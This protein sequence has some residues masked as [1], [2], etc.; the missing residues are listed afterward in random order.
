MSVRLPILAPASASGDEH[1]FSAAFAIL[2]R[3]LHFD[4][5]GEPS[6]AA[7]VGRAAFLAS[8]AVSEGHACV[9]LQEW[10]GRADAPEGDTGSAL[11]LEAW[12]PRLRESPVIA[13]ADA[14]DAFRPLVLDAAGRLFLYR[15]WDYEGR[16]AARLRALN[17]EVPL[18]DTKELR[19]MLDR[20]FPPGAGGEPDW[21]KVAAATA[22]S[23]RLAGISGGPGTGKTTTVV[24][25]LAILLSVEPKLRV[26]LAAP[27]G[28][29]AARMQESIRSQLESL[30]VPEEVRTR[31]PDTAYT[32]HR[33]LG[34]IPDSVRFRHHAEN[35]LAFDLVIV[36]EASM[37]DL[38]LAAKLLDALPPS[39]RLILLGDKDQLAS[40]ETGVVFAEVCAARGA[41][42][43]GRRQIAD[44]VGEKLPVEEGPGSGGL[45]DAVVWLTHSYRFTGES[46][47]GRL[48]RAVNAGDRE[49]AAKLLGDGDFADLRWERQLPGAR[50]LA[51][52]LVE[53]YAAFIE[54][55]RRGEPADRVLVEFDRYRVL[56][57]QREGEFGA[58]S[59]SA[60]IG[61]L[62]RRR[63]GRAHL[64]STRWYPGRPVLVT[65]NDYGLR[66][67]NGDVGVA[68]PDSAGTLLVHFPVA[69]GGTRTIAPG[70]LADCETAFAMTVHKAQGSEFDRVDL[71]LPPYDS[72]VLTRELIYTALTRPRSGLRVWASEEV[73]GAAIGRQTARVS[74]LGDRLRG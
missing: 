59:L 47:I 51:E 48:A 28:K 16:T 63:L 40:V 44:L 60:E 5:G 34:Y 43:G 29:A 38:A 39:G 71:V 23:R 18:R 3:Q 35:P 15:Y 46:G 22:I 70:R 66:V 61:E 24:K 9:A 2:M 7:D 19:R 41:S 36:D 55:V 14:G 25:I 49:S 62:F 12:L 45:Q 6:A 8:R 74:G 13:T 31:M 69:G 21:Q 64:A 56:C 37:L 53:G 67:F 50:E 27:T 26:A 42:P 20:Y 30:Q 58:P 1:D 73:L 33:L 10:A 32:V 17:A 11:P 54:A 57:A 68:L 52:R 4:L 65:R 72:R